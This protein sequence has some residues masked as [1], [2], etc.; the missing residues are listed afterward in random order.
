MNPIELGDGILS[1]KVLPL[2]PETFYF[3]ADKPLAADDHS[4]HKITETLSIDSLTL[5]SSLFP[6]FYFDKYSRESPFG[7]L[8]SVYCRDNRHTL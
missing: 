7:P 4:V 6:Y 2:F 1:A 8:W 5:E 3:P